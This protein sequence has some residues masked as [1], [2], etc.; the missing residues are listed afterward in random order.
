MHERTGLDLAV[1]GRRGLQ[2]Q[3]HALVPLPHGLEGLHAVPAAGADFGGIEV[4]KEGTGLGTELVVPLE[5]LG[6]N[7]GDVNV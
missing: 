1:E 2:L 6:R 4:P 7:H 5:Q 3:S